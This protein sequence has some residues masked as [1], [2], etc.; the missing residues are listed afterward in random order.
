MTPELSACFEDQDSAEAL[1][2]MRGR[3]L[4]H[5]AVLRRDRRLVGI[6]SL[7]DMVVSGAEPPLAGSAMRWPI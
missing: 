1:K 4:R 6:V 5:L 2:L 7:R 3:Q